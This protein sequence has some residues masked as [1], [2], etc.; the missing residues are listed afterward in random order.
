MGFKYAEAI[1]E[2]ERPCSLESAVPK[3]FRG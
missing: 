1:R 3:S 2:A